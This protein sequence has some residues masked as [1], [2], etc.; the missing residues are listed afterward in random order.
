MKNQ[1]IDEEE[2]KCSVCNNN[3]YLYGNN[4]YICSCKEKLCQFCINKHEKN[5][6]HNLILF[7]NRYII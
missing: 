3:K 7:N 6:K 5:D 1:I 4:F 2:I